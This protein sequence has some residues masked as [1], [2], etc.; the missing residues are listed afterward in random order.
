[1]AE[2]GYRFG[3]SPS[4]NARLNFQQP[5]PD[6]ENFELKLDIK[7]S[8]R[9]GLLWAWANY[10]SFTKYFYLYIYR[11]FIVVEVKGRSEPKKIHYRH[12]KI[13][14]DQ[15]HT[16]ELSKQGRVMSLKVDEHPAEDVQDVPNPKVMK[17]RMYIGNVISKH[18]RQ[19]NITIPGYQG[20]IKNFAV[21]GVV[22]DLAVNSRDVIG[23][24]K[25]NE[26]D[27]IHSGGFAMFSKQL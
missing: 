12:V 10:K 5:Y 13:N 15:W 16:V 8:Q 20:C 1:M 2:Q 25:S 9:H 27:Y 7:T 19:F 17:K 23:C 14:D 24:V 11:G 3:V 26:V 4:S 22:Q 6:Y 21:N 18:R